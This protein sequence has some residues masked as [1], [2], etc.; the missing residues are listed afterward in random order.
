MGIKQWVGYTPLA[1]AA[2][3]DLFPNDIDIDYAVRY[4]LD[5]STL[6]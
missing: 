2:E 6:C 4:P 5:P 1:V 3:L